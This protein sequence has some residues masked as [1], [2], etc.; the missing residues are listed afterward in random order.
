M[1][2]AIDLVL[3]L[4]LGLF[5]LIVLGIAS[6]EGVLRATLV[7]MGIGPAGQNLVL[8]LVALVLIIGAIRFFGGI[9]AILITVMLV[10]LMLHILLPALGVRA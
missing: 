5:H 2:Q 8:V 6:I 7:P 10:L 4:I 1:Q 3:S 9:F